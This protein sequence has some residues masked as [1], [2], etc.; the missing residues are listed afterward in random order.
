MCKGMPV[1]QNG[2]QAGGFQFIVLDDSGLQFA[3]AFDN[4]AHGMRFTLCQILGMVFQPVEELG[5]QDHS[6]LDNF[7]ES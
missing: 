6:V 3:T 4:M 7:G 5:I 1:I 2:S